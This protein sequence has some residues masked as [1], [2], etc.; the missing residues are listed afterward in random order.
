MLLCRPESRI[1]EVIKWKRQ[2]I[3]VDRHT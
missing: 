3:W 2:K 1:G